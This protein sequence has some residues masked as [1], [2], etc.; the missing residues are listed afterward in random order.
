MSRK[1]NLRFG[2]STKEKFMSPTKF[3]FNQG[4]Q[5]KTKYDIERRRLSAVLEVRC[6]KLSG[7]N[8]GAASK[9]KTTE[10]A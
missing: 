6:G 2:R 4:K 8:T 1:L 3:L 10:K 9:N 5:A 7:V